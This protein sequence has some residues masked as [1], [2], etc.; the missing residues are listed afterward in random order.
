MAT[1]PAIPLNLRGKFSYQELDSTKAVLR[2]VGSLTS[3]DFAAVANLFASATMTALEGQYDAELSAHVKL[4]ADRMRV[5][6][7]PQFKETLSNLTT[8]PVIPGEFTGRVG[9]AMTSATT[10][11]SP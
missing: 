6:E 2:C 8:L 5:Y 11:S 4:L 9:F 3:A 10:A 1:E 7:L